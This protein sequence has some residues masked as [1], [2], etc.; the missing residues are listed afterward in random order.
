MPESFRALRVENEPVTASFTWRQHE[1][2]RH[3]PVRNVAVRAHDQ[4]IEMEPGMAEGWLK[5]AK[6]AASGLFWTSVLLA[7]CLLLGWLV[8]L[9]R[10]RVS[11]L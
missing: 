10:C 3:S 6:I 5:L 1:G 4:M 9:V 7:G 8:Y 2:R 11:L